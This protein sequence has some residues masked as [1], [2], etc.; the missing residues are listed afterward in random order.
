MSSSRDGQDEAPIEADLPIVDCHH[1]LWIGHGSDYLIKDF[2]ADID[3][4]GHN[5]VA[6]VYVE[7]TAFY[8]A[9][10]P[11]ELRPV[12]EAEFV[13]GQGAMADS[14]AYGPARLCAGFVGGADLALGAAVTPVLE[15]LAEGSRG[16]LRGIRGMA[17]WDADPSVNTG[18]R[19]FGPQGLLASP[20]FRQGVV[21]LAQNGLTYDAW[22]YHPQLP[23][24]IELAKALPQVSMVINH[25]GGLLGIRRYDSPENFD[26]WRRDIRA[27]AE[28]ENVYMKL[29]GLSAKRCGFDFPTGCRPSSE[30]LAAAWKPYIETC[31]EAFGVQRCMFE[32]NFPPDK[33]LADYN[34]LWNAFKR[35][36]RSCS[37]AEKQALYNGTATSFYKLDLPT[38]IS[39]PMTDS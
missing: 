12:G 4:S 33:V 21:A 35:I 22:Q 17:N 9:T 2:A 3:V 23:E 7:C 25:C 36:T 5:V 15:A 32:A 6:S 30:D 26:T 24:V 18:V 27:A 11:V 28:C 19:P 38:P 37:P 20:A 10:G 34:R 8:R 13:A 1:H 14:G 31:I 39:T 29:G 16:R